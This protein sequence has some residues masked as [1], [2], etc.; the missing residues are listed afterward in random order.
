MAILQIIYGIKPIF[1]Q[2]AIR[3]KEVDE[4]AK[5]FALDLLD[6]M[7][8]EKAVGLGANMVGIAKAVIVV[9][10]FKNEIKNPIIAFNPEIIWKSSTMQTF[11]EASL[12]FP[13]VS[14]KIQRPSEIKLQYID[15]NNQNQE[16][17]AKGF[18][19]SVLQHEIDYLNGITIF[20]HVSKMKKDLMI[21]KM[22]KFIKLH[23]PH[24]H[25]HSCRH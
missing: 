9:D 6:T 7:Y 20:D 11:E 16:L 22:E 19:A 21:S 3:Y 17:V 23:P 15:I 24:I 2:K 12:S 8:H 25:S 18:L 10:L 13:S 1:K 4:E 14:A 5:N